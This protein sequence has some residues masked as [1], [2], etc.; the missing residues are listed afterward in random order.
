MIRQ[1]VFRILKRIAFR[2]RCDSKSYI[3]Y[4]RNN[5]V[6]VADSAWIVAPTKVTIDMTRPY[7]IS[8]GE[9]TTIT[10]GVTILTHGFDW[11]VIK[12]DKGLILGSAGKVEIGNNVFIGANTTILKGTHIGD[13]VI[14]AA[15]S[16]VVGNIPANTVAMGRPCKPCMTLDEYTEK[17]QK[18]QCDEAAELVCSYYDRYGK[19][20]PEEELAEFCMLFATPQEIMEKPVFVQRGCMGLTR[21]LPGTLI[22][23]VPFFNHTSI[24]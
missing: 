19:V 10:E 2:E 6:C 22:A 1:K 12:R 9:Y 13:N 18:R 8:I 11:S 16:L 21:V 15:G 17:R 4:L 14:I 7:L 3:A 23:T 24:F 20:P 5:G